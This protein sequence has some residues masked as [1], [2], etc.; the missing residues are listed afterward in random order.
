MAGPSAAARPAPAGALLPPA[1]SE[2][3]GPCGSGTASGRAVAHCSL[4]PQHSAVGL[5]GPCRQNILPGL[6]PSSSFHSDFCGFWTCDTFLLKL[7]CVCGHVSKSGKG[8]GCNQAVQ[9]RVVSLYLQ[10][11]HRENEPVSR[12]GHGAT[13]QGWQNW[14]ACHLPQRLGALRAVSRHPHSSP[15]RGPWQGIGGRPL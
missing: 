14:M 6:S 3:E 7:I 8:P 15:A 1:S 12:R 5:G 2:A 10:Y 11:S 9:G 4:C 13:V